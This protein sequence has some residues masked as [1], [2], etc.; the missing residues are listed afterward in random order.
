MMTLSRTLTFSGIIA[1]A[2]LIAGLS[3]CASPAKNTDKQTQV[4][5]D[6][7]VA[8][9][10]FQREAPSA[11]PIVENAEGI[12]MCPKVAKAGFVVGV[13]GGTCAMR[14]D[15]KTAEYYR[16]SSLKAGLLAGIESH[17]LM[18]TF[19]TPD[20]LAKFREGNRNWQVGGNISVAVAKKGASGTYDTKTMKDPI[21]AFV[22]S[23]AGLMADLSLDGSTFKKLEN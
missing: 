18:L 20:A 2:A 9:A 6:V 8:L 17:A 1:G 11:W 10:Q 5:T 14:I 15:G 3:G 4:E 12:L 16:T 7:D 23:E 21:T 13:E 19:N 22:F